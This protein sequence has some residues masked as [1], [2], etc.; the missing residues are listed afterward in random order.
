[1]RCIININCANYSAAFR[2]IL[3]QY[4]AVAADAV[5]C[6]S[7]GCS[8]RV[9]FQWKM[10]KMFAGVRVTFSAE[11]VRSQWA[12]G[13]GSCSQWCVCCCDAVAV[14]V[15]WC[16]RCGRR[17]HSWCG[18]RVR[19]LQQQQQQ[20]VDKASSRLAIDRQRLAHCRPLMTSVMFLS[21]HA[22]TSSVTS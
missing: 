4:F 6:L 11:S 12:G 13:G 20:Q 18:R 1:M 16:C 7:L 17:L 5:A 22:L 2:Q 10:S 3:T 19:R 21:S 15:Q 9:Q 14:V 8:T